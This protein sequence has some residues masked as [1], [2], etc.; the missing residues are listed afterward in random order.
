[1]PGCPPEGILV[2]LSGGSDS[3]A[4][5]SLLRERYEGEIAAAHLEHGFRGAA[6]VADADFVRTYCESIGIFCYV[7]HV[8]VPGSRRGGESAEMAGRRARYDF[9]CEVAQREGFTWIATGHTADDVV[10]TMLLNLFRGTGYR[11]LSGIAGRRGKIVRPL[12]DCRRGDLRA[13]LAE[14]NIPWREDETNATGDYRRNKIRNELLPWVRKNLNESVDR[15]LLGL[16][17][18]SLE[19]A[20]EEEA[21]AGTLCDALGL[22][23]PDALAVWDLR[24]ARTLSDRKRCA[25]LREQGRRLSLPVLDR[26]RTEELSRLIARS[27]RWRFQWAGDVEVVARNGFLCWAHRGDLEKLRL[28]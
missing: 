28:D 11:G 15:V 3:M 5:L 12:I 21:E 26:K 14:R 13:Y 10:E 2:A 23:A 17:H 8:D 22:E 4:L 1:M 18:E 16:A 9:F 19:I 24:R 27:G 20:D 25:A 6:S 7:K